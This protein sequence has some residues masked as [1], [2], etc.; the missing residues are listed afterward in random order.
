MLARHQQEIQADRDRE[1][2]AA[3]NSGRIA[4]SGPRNGSTGLLP[5]A[6]NPGVDRSGQHSGVFHALSELR[7]AKGIRDVNQ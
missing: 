1:L 5:V 2:Q 6:D 7:G 3:R 4:A